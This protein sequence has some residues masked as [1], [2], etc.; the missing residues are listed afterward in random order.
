MTFEAK[1]TE[2]LCQKTGSDKLSQTYY[3]P[4]KVTFIFL[5]ESQTWLVSYLMSLANSLSE[6]AFCQQQ[7]DM[8]RLQPTGVKKYNHWWKLIG[9][10]CLDL[11][12]SACTVTALNKAHKHNNI[13]VNLWKDYVTHWRKNSSCL[14]MRPQD[15]LQKACWTRIGSLLYA[16][17][18]IL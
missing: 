2:S 3:K 10:A 5:I 17:D 1:S 14:L 11:K 16:D 9:L 4:L 8:L 15:V 6:H 18:V 7:K 12:D 13:I